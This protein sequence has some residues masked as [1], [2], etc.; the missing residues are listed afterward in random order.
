MNLSQQR[1]AK[2]KM[3]IIN[4]KFME[5]RFDSG[6][7][8]ANEARRQLEEYFEKLEN[9]GMDQ[10]LGENIEVASKNF[11]LGLKHANFTF[12]PDNPNQVEKIKDIMSQANQILQNYGENLQEVI[13]N[14]P[15]INQ[16][17]DHIYEPI[18]HYYEGD[19]PKALGEEPGAELN[20]ELKPDAK[21]EYRND[22]TPP[23][24]G[25]SM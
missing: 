19:K 9:S 16:A 13:H 22:Y 8:R 23:T 20:P 2:E 10:E 7:E 11:S 17:F 15:Y 24:P 6:I 21:P 4:P 14:Y 25:M 18:D 12:D 3:L 5:E 1:K